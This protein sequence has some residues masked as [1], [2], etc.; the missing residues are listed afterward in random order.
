MHFV[1]LS[2]SCLGVVDVFRDGAEY[3]DHFIILKKKRE[4]FFEA[5]RSQYHFHIWGIHQ[6]R[7]QALQLQFARHVSNISQVITP[8]GQAIID[9][10]VIIKDSDLSAFHL[11]NASAFSVKKTNCYKTGI[12][13]IRR[14]WSDY[15]LVRVTLP[16]ALTALCVSNNHVYWK[17]HCSYFTQA[18]FKICHWY[19]I[20][21]T[22]SVGA[23]LL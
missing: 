3:K 6:H 11:Y 23:M 1:R 12:N 16:S 17:L 22:A 21:I 15:S 4:F 2:Y 8:S 10:G 5:Q 19:F 7:T 18:V 20:W 9:Y 13:V 14:L